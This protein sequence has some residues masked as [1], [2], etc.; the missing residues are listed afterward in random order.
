M[1]LIV[2]EKENPECQR[3]GILALICQPGI[4]PALVFNVFF[5]CLLN[6][7]TLKMNLPLHIVMT[8]TI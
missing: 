8:L 5:N 3:F 1:H 2:K 6:G 4:L 7:I